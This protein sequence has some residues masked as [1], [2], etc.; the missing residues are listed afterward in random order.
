[1]GRNR[2]QIRDRSVMAWTC[3]LDVNTFHQC[4][5]LIASHLETR[6]NRAVIFSDSLVG[7][8]PLCPH[9]GI[10]QEIMRSMYSIF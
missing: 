8:P 7:T 5:Y 2:G 6:S 10:D 1:M 9:D 3:D 4:L